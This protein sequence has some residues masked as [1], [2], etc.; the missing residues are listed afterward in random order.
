MN[1][2][3]R[4]SQCINIGR[5]V[6]GWEFKNKNE[7]EQTQEPFLVSPLDVTLLIRD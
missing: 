4:H 2:K 3:G 6:G 5:G 1:A 7:K